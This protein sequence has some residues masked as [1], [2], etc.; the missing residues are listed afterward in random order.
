LR[1]WITL[2]LI[3]GKNAPNAYRNGE[4]TDGDEHFDSTDTG[5]LGLKIGFAV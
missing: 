2:Q 3:G 5:F 1:R 4:R